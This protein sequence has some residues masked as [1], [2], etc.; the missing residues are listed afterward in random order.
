MLLAVHADRFQLRLAVNDAHEAQ[1]DPIAPGLCCAC[2][3]K[4]SRSPQEHLQRF[5][6]GGAV[7]IAHQAINDAHHIALGID[8]SVGGEPQS[9]R[10]HILLIDVVA[11][12]LA[13][14]HIHQLGQHLI[15]VAIDQARDPVCAADGDVAVAARCHGRCLDFLLGDG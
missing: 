9:I 8:R 13:L 15:G 7:G 12:Q 4:L 6:V 2:A 11:S 3:I 10:L 14:A 5:H 1:I